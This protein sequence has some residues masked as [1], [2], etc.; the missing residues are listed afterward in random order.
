MLSSPVTLDVRGPLATLTIS[1]AA[2]R[3]RLDL[4]TAGMLE[5]LVRNVSEREELRV[6]VITGEDEVFCCGV[7]LDYVAQ[8]QAMGDVDSFRQFLRTG[9]NLLFMFRRMPQL[10][11]AAVNGLTTG[12][13]LGLVL[14]SDWSVA[15]EKAFFGETSHWDGLFPGWTTHWLLQERVGTIRSTELVML[16][17]MLSAEEALDIG[18]INRLVRA[19][20]LAQC[21]SQMAAKFCEAPPLVLREIK[22]T[23]YENH[24]RECEQ[25]SDLEIDGQVKCFL[26]EDSRAGVQAALANRRAKFEGR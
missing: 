8:I 11:I 20:N 7:D 23:I 6:L 21:A 2:H 1:R 25:N 18:L 3:N 14:A 5:Q 9:R 19:D 4:F 10:V 24:Y 22:R 17:Q 13:G 16:G 15:C 12:A 26:S